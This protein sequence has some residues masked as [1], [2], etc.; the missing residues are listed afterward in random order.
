[1]REHSVPGGSQYTERETQQQLHSIRLRVI[2]CGMC[3]KLAMDDFMRLSYETLHALI[4]DYSLR[5]LNGLPNPD[6]GSFGRR[7]PYAT[8]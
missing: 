6:Y 3:R 2:R 7:I 1:M 5:E 4:I 8:T